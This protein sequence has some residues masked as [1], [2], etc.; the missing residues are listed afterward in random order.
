MNPS[1]GGKALSP[2]EGSV[3]SPSLGNCFEESFRKHGARTAV[4]FYRKG[5][6]ESGVSYQDLDRD[7][8]RMARVLR[9]R[10]VQK[11]DRVILF[12]PKSLLFVTTH[13]AL[14]KLGALAVPLNPGFKRSEMGHFLGDARPRL[15]IC[16][17]PR[18]RHRSFPGISSGSGR[19]S[20]R[21]P[22]SGRACPRP[23]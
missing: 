23:A 20:A 4:T 8:N 6:P 22:W 1:S 18:A 9:A 10:G 13:L 14:Q 12:F 5:R 11:G 7:A 19:R 16:S 21:S 3:S 2:D 17:G 15:V